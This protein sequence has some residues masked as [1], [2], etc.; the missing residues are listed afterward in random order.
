[1]SILGRI[2][3]AS[4]LSGAVPVGVAVA[5]YLGAEAAFAIG[6]LTHEFAPFWP[7]NVILLCAFLTAPRRQWPLII[8]FC[9]PVHILAERGVDMPSPQVLM[10]FCSNIAV[11]LLNAVLL[12]WL[13]PRRDWLS[14]LRNTVAYLGVA[15]ILS[16]ALVACLAA[17]EPLLGDGGLGDYGQ[18]WW[19]WYLSNALGNLT[20]TPVFLVWAPDVLSRRLR[21]PDRRRLAEIAALTL[22]LTISCALAFG[23]RSEVGERPIPALIY[24]P[25]PFLLAAAVRFGVKGSTGAIIIFTVASIVRAMDQTGAAAGHSVLSMQLFLAET[26]IPAMLLGAVVEELQRRNRELAAALNQRNRAEIAARATE[27]LLQSSL[28]ALNAQFA[29]LDGAGVILTANAGWSKAAELVAQSGERYFIGDNYLEECERGRPHQREL[30]AGLRRIVDGEIAEFRFE[31]R[32]DF[33]HGHW[34]Q[35]RAT[36]FVVDGELRVVVAHEDITEIKRSEDAL[37]QLSGRLMRVEDES[38]RQIARDLHDSTAQN[39]LAATLG[40]GQALRRTPRLAR[41]ARAAL[42]E[43]RELIDQS[44]REIRTV[45]YLLHPPVLDAAGLPAALRWLCNGFS[46]RT[47]IRVNLG[48]MQDIGRLPPEVEAA[49]FRIAQEALTNVHRHSG[50]HSARV[51][52]KTTALDSKPHIVLAIED[53]GRGIS[54]GTAAPAGQLPREPYPGIGLTGMRE[55]LR[56]LGGALRIETGAHGTSVFAAIP[57]AA[58]DAGP[59]TQT[60]E[61]T[62]SS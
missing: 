39:L 29:I 25:M 46:K 9:L 16:P 38:R 27:T 55:R 61:T 60:R 59:A 43:S 37:R 30:A 50:S 5:Y 15:V 11:A 52:L 53:D 49:L 48:K 18:F 2:T 34:F 24:L 45:V 41:A 6:T 40:I 44:Q 8:L 28:N 20:L 12:L 21:P 51:S 19:R 47:E 31:F 3:R 33:V 62:L 32:S 4:L 57:Y 36:R 54:A 13:L 22:G 35:M 1:M 10:A 26:A 23:S 56:H 14:G 42:E 58:G 7:P 17:F